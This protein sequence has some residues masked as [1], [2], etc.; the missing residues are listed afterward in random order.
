MKTI[1][2]KGHKVKVMTDKDFF[3]TKGLKKDRRGVWYDPNDEL[4]CL[5]ANAKP[6]TIRMLDEASLSPRQKKLYS[7]KEALELRN[8]SLIIEM[9]NNSKKMH[10]KNQHK[11]SKMNKKEL[12]VLFDTYNSANKK[13]LEKVSLEID[14]IEKQLPYYYE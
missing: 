12:A 7:R 6:G 8:S 4:D 3:N 13:K 11:Y 9:I 10:R 1:N 5:I 2:I 14:Q